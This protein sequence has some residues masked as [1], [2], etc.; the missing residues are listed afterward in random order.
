MTPSFVVY[1]PVETKAYGRLSTISQLLCHVERLFDVSNKAFFPEPKV[2]STVIKVTPRSNPPIITNVEKLTQLCFQFRRKTI[3][4][5]L[6]N[7]KLELDA[8]D[9]LSKCNLDKQTR[10]ENITPEKFLELSEL[11][12]DA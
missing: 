2:M 7:S 8:D 12:Y 1:A 3:H 11:V 4:N 6:K 5:I 9:I 10:P